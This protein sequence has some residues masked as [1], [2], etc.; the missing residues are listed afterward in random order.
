[1]LLFPCLPAT[2]QSPSSSPPLCC[3]LGIMSILWIVG[4]HA[5]M[6][7]LCMCVCVGLQADVV[8]VS[9]VSTHWRIHSHISQHIDHLRANPRPRGLSLL[10]APGA[11]P[12]R[13]V[14]DCGSKASSP[15]TH[16]PNLLKV[17][18]FCHQCLSPP[19]ISRAARTPG[20]KVSHLT[21]PE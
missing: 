16:S 10:L 9:L 18:V 6:C 7:L 11:N 2:P 3:G 21:R 12:L 20:A 4:V 1:M 17:T 8:I 13:L 5:H 19:S 15:I 14:W